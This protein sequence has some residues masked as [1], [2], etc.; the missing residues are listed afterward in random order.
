MKYVMLGFL[1]FTFTLVKAGEIDSTSR[2]DTVSNPLS[3]WFN[4]Y[5][6]VGIG[7]DRANFFMPAFGIKIGPVNTQFS[8][9][10]DL[11][12]AGSS[13][14]NVMVDLFEMKPG[15]KTINQ[16]AV[17]YN[18]YSSYSGDLSGNSTEMHGCMI[19]R[20]SYF[21]N[22]LWDFNMKIGVGRFVTENWSYDFDTNITTSTY[23][24]GYFPLV[25]VG[26]NIHLFHLSESC[27]KTVF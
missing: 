4:P 10:D 23:K 20:Y 13:A 14:I 2:V 7:M 15:K 19:G 5:L 8:V 6:S 3:Y 21:K 27:G 26:F 12:A 16:F 22:K 17:G 25:A 11:T 1:F 9:W 24:K 18:Y